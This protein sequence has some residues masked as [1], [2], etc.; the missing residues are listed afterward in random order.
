[1]NRFE[2]I[3]SSSNNLIKVILLQSRCTFMNEL[4]PRM[5]QGEAGILN[6]AQLKSPSNLLCNLNLNEIF[7]P[8]ILYKIMQK[9][10]NRSA[11]LRL[12]GQPAFKFLMRQA[13][14]LL[15]FVFSGT[16][17]VTT[18]LSAACSASRPP[19]RL[20]SFPCPKAKGTKTFWDQAFDN[21]VVH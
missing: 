12:F 17:T 11:N 4:D 6:T 2:K 10:F 7:F 16:I 20:Q 14:K 19:I 8:W 5:P 15:I 13:S 1:M 3:C 18:Y 9:E 21:Y